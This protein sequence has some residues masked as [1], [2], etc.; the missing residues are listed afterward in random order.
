[1]K[2]K[3]VRKYAQ[4]SRLGHSP[5]SHLAAVLLVALALGSLA[6]CG[7]MFEEFKAK[8]EKG[9][10]EAQFKL[11]GCYRLGVG[12]AKEAPEAVK[13]YRKAAEQGHAQ[14]QNNLGICYYTG[15]G[16]TSD[17]VEAAKWF[18]KAAEQQ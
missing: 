4:P 9:D 1:M 8:A 3:P 12:V 11:G 6:F 16:V 7:E 5:I 10:A 14:A 17:M 13:W 2:S 15:N 18:R